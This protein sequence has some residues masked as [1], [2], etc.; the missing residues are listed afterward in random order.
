MLS[1]G[2][3]QG[4]LPAVEILTSLAANMQEAELAVCSCLLQCLIMLH[5]EAIR[6]VQAPY[7]AV[8]VSGSDN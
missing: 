3:C 8:K 1:R 6:T 7:S 5:C 2:A 4:S